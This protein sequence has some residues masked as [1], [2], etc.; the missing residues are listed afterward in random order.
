MK[1]KQLKE[2]L[3]KKKALI[4]DVREASEYKKSKEKVRGARNIPMGKV[5]LM[6][7]LNKL[8]KKKKIVV[9]CLYGSRSKIVAKELKKK[10]YNIERVDGGIKGWIEY[11]NS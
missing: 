6:H 11:N 1:P 2:L 4:V 9:M 8:P 3:K 10:G 7:S 5:F